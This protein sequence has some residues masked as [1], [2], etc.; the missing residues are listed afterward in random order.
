MAASADL[1]ATF[2]P[3]DLDSMLYAQ[4]ADPKLV[5]P[6]LNQSEFTRA[7]L[8]S[9]SLEGQQEAFRKLNE[10]ALKTY[11]EDDAT[12]DRFEAPLRLVHGWYGDGDISTEIATRN[13]SFLGSIPINR[14]F[15]GSYVENGW[16]G[17]VEQEDLYR[18]VYSRNCRMCHVQQDVPTKNFDTYQEF[19]EATNLD[20]TVFETGEMPSSRLTLD[21]FWVDFNGAP[22]SAAELLRNHLNSIR[23]PA[24]QIPAD[25]IPG[26][27]I[28]K[29]VASSASPAAQIEQSG[30]LTLRSAVSDEVLGATVV[31]DGTSSLFADTYAWSVMDVGP[32]GC[33]APIVSGSGSAQASFVVGDSPCR[34]EARLDINGGASTATL[35]VESDLTPVGTNF[36]DGLAI[37]VAPYQPFDSSVELDIVAAT[38]AASAG[39]GDL[40]V[41]GVNV[42]NAAN[43]AFV[44]AS[45]ERVVFEFPLFAG[46]GIIPVG[47][48]HLGYM[49]Q[50]LDGDMAAGN[51]RVPIDPIVPYVTGNVMG[52]TIELEWGVTQGATRLGLTGQGGS[53][54]L[55]RNPS[56]STTMPSCL[57]SAVCTDDG[58]LPCGCTDQV[59]PGQVYEYRVFASLNG[60]EAGSQTL[61]LATLDVPQVSL[62][63]QSSSPPAINVTLTPGGGANVSSYRIF[64]TN[65]DTNV[66]VEFPVAASMSG[67]TVFTDQGV[68]V[69]DQNTKYQYEVSQDVVGEGTSARSPAQSII[70]D[71]EPPQSL[72]VSSVA[73]AEMLFNPPVQVMTPVPDALDVAWDL[74]ANGQ[75][76]TYTVMRRLSGSLTNLAPSPQQ[77]FEDSG[78]SSNTTYEYMVRATGRDRSSTGQSLSIL[79]SAFVSGT[80]KPSLSDLN[81]TGGGIANCGFSGC[82]VTPG[83]TYV[84]SISLG[85]ND[86][87]STP[88]QLDK[89]LYSLLCYTNGTRVVAL[90]NLQDCAPNS[91]SMDLD[92]DQALL[93]LIR[94]FQDVDE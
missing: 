75:L 72:S 48:Y 51:V 74:P 70:T 60:E 53:Y 62:A 55:E 6:S 57:P 12:I 67:S 56:F 50:D 78:L 49:I 61:V 79:Q 11:V 66:S 40:I 77:S 15:D 80:T 35:V 69:I 20:S 1:K 18:N 22:L 54:R 91:G 52:G 32:Y 27:P 7:E 37:A 33:P 39:D 45:G 46:P 21:R 83:P 30:D 44:D 86:P 23:G 29:I 3:W 17:S 90:P 87:D 59:S 5:D 16:T 65:L 71:V 76:P 38:D 9:A 24:E 4:A 26:R 41:S 42:A 92:I 14:T 47:Q 34:Y 19:V 85:G 84:S 89:E 68:G 73:M 31:L 25:A 82:H 28:A 10:A 64:R 93:D 13:K 8:A 88:N 36:S 63:I 43:G 81:G 58:A 2:M 94:R